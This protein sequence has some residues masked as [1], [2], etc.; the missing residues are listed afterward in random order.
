M[1]HNTNT[2]AYACTNTDLKILEEE[3]YTICKGEES[4]L[5]NEGRALIG[6]PFKEYFKAFERLSA[7]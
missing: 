7:F 3:R 5:L 2:L 4:I 6:Q 1:Q